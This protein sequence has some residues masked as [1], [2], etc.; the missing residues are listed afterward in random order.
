MRLYP[1]PFLLSQWFL[2]KII[3]FISINLNINE[4]RSNHLIAPFNFIQLFNCFYIIMVYNYFNIFSC[5]IM[6]TLYVSQIMISSITFLFK[7]VY[8]LLYFIS[9]N[10]LL[11]FI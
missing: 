1:L 7:F 2:I 10:S 5:F 3:S 9:I 11:A 8:L 6:Y 4:S